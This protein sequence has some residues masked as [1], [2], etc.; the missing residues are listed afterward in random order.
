M[1]RFWKVSAGFLIVIIMLSAFKP[2]NDNYFAIIK[3]LDIFASLYKELNAFYVDELNPNTLIKTG[4]DAM[5]ESLDPYTNYI[6]ADQ[7]E[8]YRTMTT[9]EYGGIGA[10][11]QR[12]NGV[13]T[14]LMCYEG[15]P[16]EEAGIKIGDQVL[17]INGID[18]SDKSSG[19][20]STLLKGQSKSG[21]KLMISR[22]NQTDPFEVT[23][24]RE[25]ITI[26]NVTYLLVT[27]KAGEYVVQLLT[28]TIEK[29]TNKHGW[30]SQLMD[31]AVMKAKVLHAIKE[32]PEASGVQ[33]SII[34]Y[35]FRKINLDDVNFKDESID[36]SQV[37]GGKFR[38]FFAE[39]MKPTMRYFWGLLLVQFIL[40]ISSL[41]FR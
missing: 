13:N 6:P 8:N 2:A 26:K 1:K 15:Y 19:E 36:L 11:V 40:L 12:V 22:T 24:S 18:L 41:F 3:N 5:L 21:I 25:K 20:I 17:A 32:D 38:N 23:V 35:G 37:V 28:T 34:R 10:L 7:I 30:G 39:M 14:V 27:S 9:G 16:A 4:I 31:K 33:R 29:I